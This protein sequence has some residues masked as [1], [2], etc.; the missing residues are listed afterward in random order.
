MNVFRGID[1]SQAT[2][3]R[4]QYHL[5]VKPGDVGRYVLLPGDPDRVRRI[6]TYLDNVQEIAFH[7]EFRTCTGTYEGVR[8]SA[9]S[10]GIGCPSAAIA[11]E[12]LAH[13]GA[14]VFIRVGSTAALQAEIHIGDLIISI[15]AMKN[16]ATSRF[17]V[18]DCLPAVPDYFVTQYLVQAAERLAAERAYAWHVGITASDDGFYG[19]TPEWVRSL[20]GY[21]LKNIEMEASA[22]F[23]V[24]HMRG[25]RAAAICAVSSNLV[26]AETVYEGEN[27]ALVKG[28]DD[29]IVVVLEAIA[30]FDRAHGS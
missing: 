19:E 13:V 20:S 29:E 17:Y 3:G 11:V 8:I 21:R 26:T 14:E 15:G 5:H 30:E 25:L 7:R 16:E 18:P 10:T 6:A 2:L 28:W 12:E 9:T 1:K 4:P 23:T 22:I 27:P 24:A